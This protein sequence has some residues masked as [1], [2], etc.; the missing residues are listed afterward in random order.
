VVQPHFVQQLVDGVAGD[1]CQWCL[2]VAH[3]AWPQVMT[4]ISCDVEIWKYHL[5][6]YLF[7]YLFVYLHV[8]KYQ[9][10]IYICDIYIC[11]RYIH[12]SRYI[13]IS[14]YRR[15]IQ[16]SKYLIIYIDHISISIYMYICIYIWI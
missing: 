12:I 4:R 16:I 5:S 15:Y 8:C 6:I 13:Y 2:L 3:Q 9:I 10:S 1:L 14:I 11:S 7:W